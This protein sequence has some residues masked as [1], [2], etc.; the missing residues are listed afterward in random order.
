[1]GFIVKLH[2]LARDVVQLNVFRVGNRLEPLWYV[3]F[4]IIVLVS[5]R[6]PWMFW[7]AVLLICEPVKW[8]IIIWRIRRPDYRGVLA[9]RRNNFP[10]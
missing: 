4:V 1:M 5:I 7:T 3:T 8:G 9:S 10:G 2:W 6:R